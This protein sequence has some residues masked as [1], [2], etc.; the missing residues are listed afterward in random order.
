MRVQD[1][2]VDVFAVSEGLDGG[3]PGIARGR[4]NDGY[5]STLTSKLEVEQPTKQLHGDIFERQRRAVEQLDDID[6]VR[7]RHRGDDLFVGKPDVGLR[8]D[9]VEF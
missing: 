7:E 3:G 5:P 8:D 9:R 4:A 6:A 1:H 2:D